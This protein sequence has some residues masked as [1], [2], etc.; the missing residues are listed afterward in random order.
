[1]WVAV[2]PEGAKVSSSISE[3][4]GIPPKSWTGWTNNVGSAVYPFQAEQVW[5][6][7]SM[8]WPTP[9]GKWPAGGVSAK[10]VVDEPACGID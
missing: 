2:G 3:M 9:N 1:M 5:M 6:I 7:V 4:G 10:V 8:Q